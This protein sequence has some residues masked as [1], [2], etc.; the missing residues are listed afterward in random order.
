MKPSHQEF[1]ALFEQLGISK[2]QLKGDYHLEDVE[3]QKIEM[4]C[5]DD[6]AVGFC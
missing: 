5:P 3:T 6:A 1:Y 2:R 4:L